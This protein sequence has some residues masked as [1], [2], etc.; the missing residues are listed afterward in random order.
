[1]IV[2]IHYRRLSSRGTT[3]YHEGLVAD[4]GQRLTTFTELTP[5]ECQGLSKAFWNSGLLPHGY[6]L[7]SIRKHYFYNQYFDVLAVYGPAGEL[8]GYYCD[9]ATPL[10]KIGDEYYL[11]DLFLDYWLAPP[12][13]RRC[14]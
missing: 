3:I 6:L 10:R 5:K 12:V 13:T 7:S 9:I 8:A 2:N 11:E 1:M 4:D 14:I